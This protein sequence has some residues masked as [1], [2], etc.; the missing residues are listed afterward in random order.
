MI[1]TKKRETRSFE[2]RNDETGVFF[3]L[4]QES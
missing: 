4:I 1:N 3:I 2:F